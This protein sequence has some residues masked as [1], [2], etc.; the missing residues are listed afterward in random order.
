M[1][2]L[3][4]Y[5]KKPCKPPLWNRPDDLCDKL[6][7]QYQR[8][9]L[10]R[11]QVYRELEALDRRLTS[12]EHVE[13]MR[14]VIQK[15]KTEAHSRLQKRKAE[16]MVVQLKSSQP[17]DGKGTEDIE[18]LLESLPENQI[19][20]MQIHH[21][22]YRCFL[23]QGPEEWNNLDRI[24]PKTAD[25]LLSERVLEKDAQAVENIGRKLLEEEL[26]K[27]EG[28]AIKKAIR[29]T[30][31]EEEK[32]LKDINDRAR[33]Y[34]ANP[35]V[36]QHPS[37]EVSKLSKNPSMS[38]LIAPADS[39]PP[40]ETREASKEREPSVSLNPYNLTG[41]KIP[42]H[43]DSVKEQ[44]L[45]PVPQS[46]YQ[47]SVQ[48]DQNDRNHEVSSLV[49]NDKRPVQDHHKSTNQ[50][51]FKTDLHQQS[52]VGKKTRLTAPLQVEYKLP[53][54]KNRF[55]RS[56][57][58]TSRKGEHSKTSLNV[59]STSIIQN[60]ENR[61]KEQSHPHLND[62][63][64][65]NI[66]D[67][68]DLYRR[69]FVKKKLSKGSYKV[70]YGDN[71]PLPAVYNSCKDSSANKLEKK[72][73]KDLREQQIRHFVGMQSVKIDGNKDYAGLIHAT[74]NGPARLANVPYCKRFVQKSQ[75]IMKH[76]AKNR[77]ATEPSE[78]TLFSDLTS[79]HQNVNHMIRR[80]SKR[81]VLTNPNM[82]S[83]NELSGIGSNASKASILSNIVRLK[84]PCTFLPPLQPLNTC[85]GM[86]SRPAVL[87]ELDSFSKD[88][89]TYDRLHRQAECDVLKGGFIHTDP[90]MSEHSIEEDTSSA[91]S[92]KKNGKLSKLSKKASLLSKDQVSHSKSISRS[93]S[94]L[95]TEP[96]YYPEEDSAEEPA[97]FV[98]IDGQVRDFRQ[99]RRLATELIE[100]N[101]GG[102]SQEIEEA[103]EPMMEESVPEIEQNPDTHEA[104]EIQENKQNISDNP[105]EVKD[106]VQ[107][108]Q[109]KC[110]DNESKEE[111]INKTNEIEN[112]ENEQY[113]IEQTE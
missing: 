11:D 33:D 102:S 81:R 21:S 38:S 93:G 86:N 112:P 82:R 10:D 104:I 75:E 30:I 28:E 12:Q 97:D 51:V 24:N 66:F 14:A 107:E 79:S 54:V 106:K 7:D 22:G 18:N 16:R 96:C 63:S 37:R 4:T 91:N 90:D 39:V 113:L 74:L 31:R 62:L 57:T 59:P 9:R 48:F 67:R 98:G 27:A 5:S 65:A 85:E 61:R 47:P 25:I 32:L 44:A 36:L 77:K 100:K 19:D 95:R 69:L 89:I 40:P 109:E 60:T 78:V 15:S 87:A 17:V 46:I 111:N 58:N 13:H 103:P 84:A 83:T 105:I 70:N 20:K 108:D 72:R 80:S 23:H 42:E 49:L 68:K 45:S 71:S 52:S 94:R 76:R 50:N 3:S 53:I 35:S 101:Q 29:D 55:F 1:S 64:E 99:L 73:A 41:V 8:D 26:A 34:F 56:Q 6:F 2:Y 43:K 92:Y 88:R 110:Q